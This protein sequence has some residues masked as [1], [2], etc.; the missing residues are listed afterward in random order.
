MVVSTPSYLSFK[1]I[2]KTNGSVAICAEHLLISMMHIS[3][4]HSHVTVY[5]LSASFYE[6]LQYPASSDITLQGNK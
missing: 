1:Q 2:A 5:R 4:L 3:Y 6:E